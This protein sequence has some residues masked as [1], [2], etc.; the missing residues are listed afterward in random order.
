M[1][2]KA[3]RGWGTRKQ[4]EFCYGCACSHRSLAKASKRNPA[5][6][7]WIHISPPQICMQAFDASIQLAGMMGMEV[8][9]TSGYLAPAVI[10]LMVYMVRPTG[11]ALLLCVALVAVNNEGIVPPLVAVN[12]G[13]VPPLVAVYKRIV[14]PLVHGLHGVWSS[15]K[16]LGRMPILLLRVRPSVVK[17]RAF[18]CNYRC[19]TKL[20]REFKHRCRY[21]C[22][23]SPATSTLRPT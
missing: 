16:R 21:K 3:S 19:L 22:I 12:K 20:V 2:Q 15:G 11:T 13:I 9:L 1:G 10:P 5:C 23:S 18:P 17:A 4:S 6:I 7:P 8:N 14:P